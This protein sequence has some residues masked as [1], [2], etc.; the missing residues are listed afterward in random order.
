MKLPK[1]STVTFICG[2]G[3]AGMMHAHP[4]VLSALVISNALLLAAYVVLCELEAI[5]DKLG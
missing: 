5:R 4:E 1:R 2:L 3:Y